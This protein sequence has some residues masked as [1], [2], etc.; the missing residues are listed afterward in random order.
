MACHV[1]LRNGGSRLVRTLAAFQVSQ[2]EYIGVCMRTQV[3]S[4]DLRKSSVCVIL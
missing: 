1:D 2:W 4:S 3:E